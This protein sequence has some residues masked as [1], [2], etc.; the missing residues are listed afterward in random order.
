M[1]LNYQ[2]E[3]GDQTMQAAP[4]KNIAVVFVFAFIIAISGTDVMGQAVI[5]LVED[6]IDETILSRDGNDQLGSPNTLALGD[7]ND[8]GAIDYLLGAPGGDGP[9]DNRLDAGEVYVLL[10]EMTADPERA[11]DDFP[12]LDITIFG[13]QPGDRYGSGVAACDVNADGFDDIIIGAPGGKGRNNSRTDVGEVAVI[14]GGPSFPNQIDLSQ[15]DPDVIIYGGSQNSDFGGG[16]L[17]FDYNGNGVGDMVIADRFGSGPNNSR[18]R[19]GNVYVVFGSP[20][21]RSEILV[22]SS[23]LGA[24]VT[25]YGSEPQDQMGT[26]IAFGDLNADGIFD[27]VLGAPLSDG[28][29][30]SR[31]D[32]GEVYVVL[33]RRDFPAVIDIGTTSADVTVFGGD[34][35]DQLGTSV[36]AGDV[37]GDGIADLVAGAPFAGGPENLRGFSGEV[38]V[39]YGRSFIPS[40][41]DPSSE[42][43]DVIVYG[44]RQLENLGSSVEVADLNNDGI[45]DLMLG[46][47]GG[48]AE[49][50]TRAGAGKVYAFGSSGD[51]DP[52][53]DLAEF[54]VDLIVI[55]GM[56]GDNLGSALLGGALTIN[57]GGVILIGADGVDSPADGPDAGAVYVLPAADFISPGNGNGGDGCPP[58]YPLGDVDNDC[59]VTIIDAKII[60][61]SVLGIRELT[62]AQ[63][64]LADVAAPFGQITLADA[65]R[66]AE[67]AVGLVDL[68]PE[69]DDSNGSGTQSQQ[70]VKKMERVTPFS[71]SKWSIYSA[72]AGLRVKAIGT[73]ISDVQMQVYGLTGKLVYN[74]GWKS[75]T[76]VLWNSHASQSRPANGVY[77]YILK[78]RG[79]D[80]QIITSKIH[81]VAIL[82]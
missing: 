59:S 67:A 72:S 47:T 33:G 52:I 26:S 18:S 58:N 5:D 41:I 42:E 22:S 16:I 54:Q 60:C 62:E 44:A 74:S 82:R 53:I 76:D 51:L 65:I 50:G 6:L 28:P 68:E 64:E 70:A 21:L 1:K 4:L 19:T 56:T 63:F 3:E 55:G 2:N 77:L 38:L 8:D 27:L 57:G 78:A 39:V 75:G 35:E 25:I 32:G 73:G 81:K 37:N 66:V 45:F 49:N 30:S 9:N 43:I 10:G 24:D 46:A 7:F 34:A 13:T 12:G 71:L 23:T 20:D 15:Q 17:C 14:Y 31:R 29:R 36:S 40:V 11:I 48:R 80:G 69:D 61:E 79:E